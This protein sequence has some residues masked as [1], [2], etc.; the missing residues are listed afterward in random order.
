MGGSSVAGLTRSK[1]A[2]RC[3]VC[4]CDLPEGTPIWFEGKQAWCISHGERPEVGLPDEKDPEALLHAVESFALGVSVDM[5]AIRDK[6][7]TLIAQG[8]K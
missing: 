6:L 7:D 4:E 1:Y 8:A 2:A 3:I 5:R